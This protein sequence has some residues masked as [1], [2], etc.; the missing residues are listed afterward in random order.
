MVIGAQR[1]IV[2]KNPGPR[3]VSVPCLNTHSNCIARIND[4]FLD[5]CMNVD[6]CGDAEMLETL[7]HVEMLHCE[8]EMALDAHVKIYTCGDLYN[9]KLRNSFEQLFALVF[10]ITLGIVIRNCTIQLMVHK[11][12]M[13]GEKTVV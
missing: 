4:Q 8:M 11:R 6:E 7:R 1:P 13:L 3:R 2:S 9:H 5:E 10:E 12:R